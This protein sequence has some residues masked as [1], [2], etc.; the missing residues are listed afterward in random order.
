MI[1]RRSFLIGAGA[2][3]PAPFVVRAENIMKVRSYP[4]YPDGNLY[5]INRDVYF[6][7][8]I[9]QNGILA[10]VG[11]PVGCAVFKNHA[12]KGAR[13]LVLT[14]PKDQARPILKQEGAICFFSPDQSLETRRSVQYNATN[15][16]MELRDIKVCRSSNGIPEKESSV[17]YIFT[18][19]GEGIVLR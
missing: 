15:N 18:H 7:N 13:P 8:D 10:K 11:D 9:P 5:F 3:V 1:S 16:R 6:V 2:L 14:S 19:R 12:Y 4:V 17:D